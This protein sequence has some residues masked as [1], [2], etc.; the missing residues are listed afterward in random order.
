[1][2]ISTNSKELLNH[3]TNLPRKESSSGLTSYHRTWCNYEAGIPLNHRPSAY[4]Y[5]CVNVVYV[6]VCKCSVYAN[7]LFI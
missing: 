5:I 6:K 3:P 4:V 2:L 7:I 1:M